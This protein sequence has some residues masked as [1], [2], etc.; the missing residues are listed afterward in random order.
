M[1]RDLNRSRTL[2]IPQVIRLPLSALVLSAM[3]LGTT[4]GQEREY[5]RLR[6]HKEPTPCVVNCPLVA[7]PRIN[8]LES[9]IPGVAYPD[10]GRPRV[11]RLTPNN[12]RAASQP[13]TLGGNRGITGVGTASS[14][15][16]ISEADKLVEALLS[17]WTP[18]EHSRGFAI[19]QMSFRRDGSLFGHPIPKRIEVS[20]DENARKRFVSAAASAAERC[21]PLNLSPAFGESIAGQPLWFQFDAP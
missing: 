3:T 21:A 9:A 7:A 10:F 1:V 18:P 20:G 8:K 15:A 12:S 14:V 11:F 6:P 4:H 5:L 2:R 16:P 13:R 19:M 17:C